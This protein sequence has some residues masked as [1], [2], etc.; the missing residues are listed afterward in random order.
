M[1][2]LGTTLGSLDCPQSI[3][4]AFTRTPVVVEYPR[5]KIARIELTEI[6]ELPN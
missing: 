1:V 3:L 5:D 2:S 6:G 4:L